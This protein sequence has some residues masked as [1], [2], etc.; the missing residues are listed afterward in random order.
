MQQAAALVEPETDDG[1]KVRNE[2]TE[3]EKKLPRTTE[4]AGQTPVA[5]SGQLAAPSPAPKA[6]ANLPQIEL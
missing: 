5:E 2:L 6:P 4:G 1:T 3:L